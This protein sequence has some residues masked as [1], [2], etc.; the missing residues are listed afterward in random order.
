[1]R[2]AAFLLLASAVSAG[3]AAAPVPKHLMKE[4]ENTEQ[5]PIQGKW[6][7]ES[8]TVGGQ[9][10]MPGANPEISF[11]LRDNTMTVNAASGLTKTGVVKFDK[12]GGFRRIRITDV[13][14][15]GN[16]GGPAAEDD[17]SFGYRFEGDK[18]ILAARRQGAKEVAVDPKNAG[19]DAMVFVFVRVKDKN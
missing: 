1:M 15:A 17:A 8:V 12:D 16:A 9:V 14:R 11:D 7:L 4:A 3:T 13:K 19:T 18:L 6:Q 2:S 10:R 5:A